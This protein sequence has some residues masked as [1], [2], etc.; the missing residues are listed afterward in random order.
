MNQNIYFTTE[1]QANNSKCTGLS[2]ISPQFISTRS[3]EHS[4]FGNRMFADV[5]VKMR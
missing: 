2:S 3:S 4:A 5:R 1:E